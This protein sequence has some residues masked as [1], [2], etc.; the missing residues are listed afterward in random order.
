MG[1]DAAVNTDTPLEATS[2]NKEEP[3]TN[4][5]QLEQQ[6]VTDFG[7]RRRPVAVAAAEDPPPGVPHFGGVVPSGCSFWRLASEGRTFYTLPR[8]H[9][10]CPIGAYTHNIPLPPDRE[11]ELPETLGLMAQLGYVRMEEVPGIPRLPTAPAVMVYAPLG[12]TPVEPA[13]VLFSGPAA[14]IMLLQEAAM[15]AGVAT[16]LNLLGRPTC[17]AV[18]AALGHGMVTSTGCIGNRVYTDLDEGDLYAVIPFGGVARVAGESGT[19]RAAN[20]ALAEYHTERR[21][22]LT[23][24]PG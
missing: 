14:R 2:R 3:V 13:V 7:F 21:E 18:P 15:R 10:N 8:D 12:D 22:R 1:S 9:Y 20:A 11:Q 17:M 19:I 16:Q 5:R 24:M 4:Y 23:R 6:F